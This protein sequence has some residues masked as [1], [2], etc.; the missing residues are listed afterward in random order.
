MASPMATWTAPNSP[1]KM[2]YQRGP[3]AAR[4]PV[5]CKTATGTRSTPARKANRTS[6]KAPAPSPHNAEAE[7]G[8]E[9]KQ[10]RQEGDFH[11]TITGRQP[12]GLVVGL[13][14]RGQDHEKAGHGQQEEP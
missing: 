11:R 2:T 13:R 14:R 4:T 8:D 3:S 9:A 1:W 5:S 7:Q 12:E 6:Q 10:R